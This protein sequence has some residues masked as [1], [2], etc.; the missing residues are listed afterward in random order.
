MAHYWSAD[1]WLLGISS[2]AAFLGA[3][4]CPKLRIAAILIL[5]LLA[6]LMR[7]QK[8]ES[9]MPDFAAYLHEKGEIQQEVSFTVINQ[10][11]SDSYRVKLDSIAGYQLNE[12]LLLQSR[13]NLATGSSFRTVAEISPLREDPILSI[14]PNRYQGRMRAVLP[15]KATGS[16]QNLA[17]ILKLRSFLQQRLDQSLKAYSPLAK[18]LLLSDSEFKR[19]HRQSLSNAG[20]IHL[21]VVSGLHVLMLSL[22]LLVLLRGIFPKMVAE[23]I[24]MLLLLLFAAI[25]GFAP[26]ILRAMLMICLAILSRW[27]SRPLALSQNLALSLFIITIID[28]DQIFSVSLQLSFLAVALIAFALPRLHIDPD[29]SRAGKAWRNVFNYML[30]SLIVGIGIAPLSL[31]YFGTASLNGVL[32]NLLGLP[33]ITLLLGLAL[34]ILFVPLPPFILSFQALA[35][36]WEAWL[37]F[38]STLPFRLEDFWIS[39]NSALALALAIALLFLLLNRRWRLCL[40][41]LLPVGAGITLLL[42]FPTRIKNELYIFNSG[43]ADCALIFADDGSSMMIDT[44]GIL[45]QRA[46]MNISPEMNHQSW[47]KQRLLIWLKRRHVST[48]DYLVITHLH[49]DHAGGLPDILASL[50]VKQLVLSDD[51]ISRDEWQQMVPGLQLNNTRIMSINDTTSLGLG[52]YQAKVLHPDALYQDPD[53]NNQSLVIRFDTAGSSFLFTGDIEAEAERYLVEHYPRE[54]KSEILKVPH[55]GSRTSSTPS[56]LEH[57]QAR[58]AVITSSESN[59]YGFPHRE[60]MARLQLNGTQI[61]YSYLG[62]LRYVLR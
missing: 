13:E 46:E 40:R 24:F 2:L 8:Q 60:T 56:F 38:C 39:I 45:G 49:T 41:L 19:E 21:V 54:L 6:G 5:F 16:A 62:S 22:F 31:Y 37:N 17:A 26:P 12:T 61:Q 42:I 27:L 58:E 29:L 15:L 55:H 35:E 3:I 52:S 51:S 36:L 30:L 48:L 43:V 25:N 28:P 9:E 4:L 50:K 18:A 11:G 10:L 53:I 44:G 59:I 33:L 23:F 7:G 47:Y 32:A 20:I 34:L 14:Y 1:L 57:V